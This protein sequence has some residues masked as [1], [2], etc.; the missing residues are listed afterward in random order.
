MAYNVESILPRQQSGKSPCRR[1]PGTTPCRCLIVTLVVLIACSGCTDTTNPPSAPPPPRAE[2]QPVV[3]W[4][5]RYYRK[6][7]PGKE[8]MVSSIVSQGE[9]VQIMV[10]IPPDQASHLM[11]RPA[12]DQFRQV[13]EQVCPGKIEAVWRLL[14]PGSSV[15]LLPSVS[16]QVFIEVDCGH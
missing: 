14:P 1:L 15:K 3:D 11:R 16:G 7:P 12:D 10:A 4:L 2:L 8:W 6:S 13:A 9:Q 5:D